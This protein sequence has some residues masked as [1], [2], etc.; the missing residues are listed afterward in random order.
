MNRR[1]LTCLLV[2]GA[3]VGCMKPGEACDSASDCKKGDR[4]DNHICL[5]ASSG[6]SGS[7]TGASGSTGSTGSTGSSGSSG[8]S[9]GFD[10]GPPCGG[11]CV[12]PGDYCNTG[13]GTHGQCSPAYTVAF[14]TPAAGALLDGGSQPA[15]VSVSIV[16]GLNYGK[17]GRVILSVGCTDGGAALSSSGSDWTGTFAAGVSSDGPLDVC[18]AAFL[19]DGGLVASARQTVTVDVTPPTLNLSLSRQPTNTNDPSL[20]AAAFARDE[21]PVQ[22]N[23]GA[24]DATGPVTVTYQLRQEDGGAANG[25]DANGTFTLQTP[26]MGERER[27]TVLVNATDAA[28]NQASATLAVPVT[29]WKW[30]ATLPV[31]GSSLLPPAVAHDGTIFEVVNAV[32]TG[33]TP[34]AFAINVDGGLRW[35]AIIPHAPIAGAALAADAGKLFVLDNQE[36]SILL[37][38]D[39]G[40]AHTPIA[41]TGPAAPAAEFSLG[42]SSVSGFETAFVS[43]FANNARLTEIAADGSAS[44]LT[45]S[46]LSSTGNYSFGSQA[47]VG[48]TSTSTR[49]FET[50]DF[51][52][53]AFTQLDGGIINESLK[54]GPYGDSSE[55]FLVGGG[56]GVQLLHLDLTGA[57]PVETP[58]PLTLPDSISGEVLISAAS[59]ALVAVGTGKIAEVT[60]ASPMVAAD[61]A[62]VGGNTGMLL[63]TSSLYALSGAQVAAIDYGTPG[64]SHALRW[65]VDL[66][67]LS[68]STLAT[69]APS[70]ACSTHGTSW[71]LVPTNGALVALVIDEAGLN[72]SAPWPK[73]RRDF[74]NSANAALPLNA[75]P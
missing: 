40:A 29:R 56:G 65:Q 10:A 17:P 15:D 75:C 13:L 19:D 42:A 43:G 66:S 18:A 35:S 16:S 49:F 73:S 24:S 74:A 30:V 20:G 70:L 41:L 12:A 25:L 8:T 51:S 32:P 67:Q 54:G 5:P 62:Q 55:A 6:S 48:L 44:A 61:L 68:A 69:A 72:T 9:G 53:G 58:G 71:L 31:L 36:M 3:A 60:V 7:I 2:V 26:P 28:G 45:F 59:K 33:N 63:A 23:A 4:C 50:V 64:A 27:F 11:P 46:N 14:V 38:G 57:S 37:M 22:V 52:A 47:N 39:G 34:N 1:L 21:D